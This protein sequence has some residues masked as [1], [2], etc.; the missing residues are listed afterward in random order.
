MD[1]PDAL[2]DDLGPGGA[3]SGMG[4]ARREGEPEGWR[5]AYRAA[6]AALDL[7]ASDDE[8]LQGL[9]LIAAGSL[10]S[11]PTQWW[12]LGID[13]A[14]CDPEQAAQR[15]FE[16]MAGEDVDVDNPWDAEMAVATRHAAA[17]AFSRGW[18]HTLAYNEGSGVQFALLTDGLRALNARQ[19]RLGR[20]EFLA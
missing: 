9:T 11:D 17:L 3:Q 4:R 18:L 6:E 1:V 7:G 16:A 8:I 2:P 13:L 19:R 12:R 10:A 5:D 20:P 15:V 14:G